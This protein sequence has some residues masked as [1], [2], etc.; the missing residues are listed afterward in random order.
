MVAPSGNTKEEI[1]SEAP[2][3][4]SQRSMVTGR[5]AELDERLFAE[6][7]D[8]QKA[9]EISEE[10]DAAQARVD[11]LFEEWESLEAALAE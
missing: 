10:R 2:S 9:A 8:H 1:S 7:A 3:F 6:A 4:S 11:Q 5:V